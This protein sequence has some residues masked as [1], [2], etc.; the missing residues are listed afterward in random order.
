MGN[1]MNHQITKLLSE[2]LNLDLFYSIDIGNNKIRLLG[3][4][5]EDLEEYLLE[6]LF[7]QKDYLYEDDFDKVEFENIDGSVRI[8]LIID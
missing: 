5:S 1:T 8:V 6:K 2:N 4:Y 3:D 7:Q